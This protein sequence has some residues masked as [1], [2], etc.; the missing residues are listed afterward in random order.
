MDAVYDG[1]PRIEGFEL[2][3]GLSH[4]RVFLK[5]LQHTGDTD[6]PSKFGAGGRNAK[7]A[8]VLNMACAWLQNLKNFIA[9]YQ[10]CVYTSPPILFASLAVTASART[11]VYQIFNLLATRFQVLLRCRTDQT[12]AATLHSAVLEANY[13]PFTNAA[14]ASYHEVAARDRAMDVARAQGRVLA[15]LPATTTD[16]DAPSPAWTWGGGGG[17]RGRRGDRGRGDRDGGRER[18]KAARAAAARAA[19]EAAKAAARPPPAEMPDF[20]AGGA[21]PG[22][23]HN[24]PLGRGASPSAPQP[25]R[26]R[27]DG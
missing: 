5:L 6:F 21:V 9:T 15:R 18:S 22:P 7:V 13:T 2:P 23:P 11:H 16:W 26:L 8:S 17:G 3:S 24:K 25:V 20:C 10:S 4:A 19:A 12:Y 14:T 27:A 1:C